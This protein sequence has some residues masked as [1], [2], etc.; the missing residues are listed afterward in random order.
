MGA[1]AKLDFG[2]ARKFRN[3]IVFKEQH[4][5]VLDFQLGYTS[6]VPFVRTNFK[7]KCAT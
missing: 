1:I 4:L 6:R 3:V 7:E 2:K 5:T